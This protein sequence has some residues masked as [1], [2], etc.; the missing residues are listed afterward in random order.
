MDQSAG[1]IVDFASQTAANVQKAVTPPEMKSPLQKNLTRIIFG[2]LGLVILIELILGFRALTASRT[3]L[4]AAATIQSMTDPQ[5]VIKP[6]QT[7]VRAG[8]VVEVK[9]LLV[10]GGKP[11]DS[12]DLILHFD[13]NFL[14]ASSSSA[15]RVGEI[16]QDYP[17]AAVDPKQ[18]TIEVSGTTALNGQ[19]FVGIGTF[20]TFTF[21][22]LKEGKTALTVDFQ[23][24][25]TADSNVVL[26]GSSKD[27]LDKVYNAEISI[28]NSQT[29]QSS[30]ASC[31]G[32]TQYCQTP[33]GETGRQLCTQGKKS[34]GACVFDPALSVSCEVCSAQ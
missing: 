33:D 29:S 3:Q 23:K 17:V 14:E 18:G 19:P 5:I 15:I 26:S 21:K 6:A 13:P 9:A 20:A 24:G 31:A 11:T 8:Q 32:Y 16:Y 22:A 27:I 4:S 28:G 2:V 1:P 12:T 30:P 7:G 10:T 34:G 25:A